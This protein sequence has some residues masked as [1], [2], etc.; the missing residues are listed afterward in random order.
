LA[1][2]ELL[3]QHESRPAEPALSSTTTV[4]VSLEARMTGATLIYRNKN[5][6]E[7]ARVLFDDHYVP[8]WCIKSKAEPSFRRKFAAQ[9][10]ACAVWMREFDPE[11]GKLRPK[12]RRK[13]EVPTHARAS[14]HPVKLSD[15]HVGEGGAW[16]L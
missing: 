5:E 4:S 15:L 2:R 3:P 13:A 10:E 16:R 14:G 11:T 8:G 6:E 9:H 1:R 7:V 12:A